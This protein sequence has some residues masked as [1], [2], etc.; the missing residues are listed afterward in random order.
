M[1]WCFLL[2]L[3]NESLH[4]VFSVRLGT[5]P[6]SSRALAVD[7]NDWS[8][9]QI[10]GLVFCLLPSVLQ[11]VL[12]SAYLVLCSA[13]CLQPLSSRSFPCVPLGDR[14]DTPT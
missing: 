8:F 6:L 4:A 11:R 9:C 5:V 14:A 1:L 12:R 10:S 7:G 3:K 2:Y 13:V